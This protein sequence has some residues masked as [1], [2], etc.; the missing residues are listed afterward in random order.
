MNDSNRILDLFNDTEALKEKYFM[1][2]K[3]DPRFGWDK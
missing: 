3:D 1:P 2:S